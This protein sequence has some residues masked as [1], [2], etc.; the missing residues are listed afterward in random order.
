MLDHRLAALLCFCFRL[1]CKRP[2]TDRIQQPHR[3]QRPGHPRTGVDPALHGRCFPY[4]LPLTAFPSWIRGRA[5]D[6]ERVKRRDKPQP[7]AQGSIVTHHRFTDA[8]GPAD[9]RCSV[10][11]GWVRA[12]RLRAG[13]RTAWNGL[14][15][16]RGYH[17]VDAVLLQELVRCC[18]CLGKR[19]C[20]RLPKLL[21]RAT[22]PP[23]F[24][25]AQ[26]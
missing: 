8:K 21:Q 22:E 4:H 18:Y 19:R 16:S 23:Y 10:I 17:N 24:D 20:S 15:N 11:S 9:R 14:Q 12:P 2:C 26:A 6:Q 25:V 5:G 7:P 13:A 3:P 1:C